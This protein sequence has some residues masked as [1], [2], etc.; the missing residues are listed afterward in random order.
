MALLCAGL[1]STIKV[2]SGTFVQAGGR[3]PD[4]RQRSLGAEARSRQPGRTAVERVAYPPGAR[5]TALPLP[6]L[7]YASACVHRAVVG[8]CQVQ[9]FTMRDVT[10]GV[11]TSRGSSRGSSRPPCSYIRSVVSCL[12]SCPSEPCGEN[13]PGIPQACDAHNA[14]GFTV[15]GNVGRVMRA[16]T[17][18]GQRG[19]SAGA[20]RG[21]TGGAARVERGCGAPEGWVAGVRGLRLDDVAPTICPPQ[22]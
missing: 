9:P 20:D 12:L 16:G 19:S 3:P 22:P 2:R 13:L 4:V 11:L 6:A 17:G 21:Q 8:H 14:C 5:G 7:S 18:R 1:V 10:Q 15:C